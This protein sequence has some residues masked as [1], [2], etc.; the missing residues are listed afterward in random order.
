MKRPLVVKALSAL[1][2]VSAVVATLSVFAGRP[3]L[4]SALKALCAG[5]LAWSLWQLKNWARRLVILLLSLG[6]VVSVC[7]GAAVFVPMGLQGKPIALGGIAILLALAA[8]TV[9]VIRS[10]MSASVK[11]AFV[12]TPPASSP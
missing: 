12:A 8:L 10:L 4:P 1:Y 9:F 7:I 3:A 6:L 2:A 5:I 11:Q